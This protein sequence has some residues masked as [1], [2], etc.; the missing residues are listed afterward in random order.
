[1][2]SSDGLK[3]LNFIKE[4]NYVVNNILLDETELAT[5]E[6]DYTPDLA[7]TYFIVEAD[8]EIKEVTTTSSETQTY[9]IRNDSSVGDEC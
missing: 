4:K 8:N 1:M 6:I 2:S 9:R 7:N 5:D 3:Q